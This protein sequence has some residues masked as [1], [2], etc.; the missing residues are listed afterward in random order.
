M[1]NIRTNIN[2]KTQIQ[3]LAEELGLSLSALI[4]G[5]IK[6]TLRTKKIEFDLN[7]LSVPTFQLSKKMIKNL[8][9]SMV[10]FRSGKAQEIISVKELLD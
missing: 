4:N 7:N 10:D 8:D 9:Q 2:I 1:I 3:Q 5:L 6:Q